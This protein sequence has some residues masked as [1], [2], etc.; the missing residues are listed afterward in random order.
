MEA[1]FVNSYK[2]DFLTTYLLQPSIPLVYYND[3]TIQYG[4]ALCY[5]PGYLYYSQSGNGIRPI[6][7]LKPN[8]TIKSG[9]GIKDDP[10]IIG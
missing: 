6:I 1:S 7:N 2:D 8:V 10:Y 4:I 9:T 5:S 3:G